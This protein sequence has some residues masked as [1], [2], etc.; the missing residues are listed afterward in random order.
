MKPTTIK[1]P[2]R[3]GAGLDYAHARMMV[4]PCGAQNLQVTSLSETKRS[5]RR[6][7]FQITS[8]SSAILR[9]ISYSEQSQVLHH[10]TLYH[11]VIRDLRWI[12]INQSKCGGDLSRKKWATLLRAGISQRLSRATPS[13]HKG[14]NDE[15]VPLRSAMTRLHIPPTSTIFLNGKLCL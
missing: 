9:S 12:H 14:V 2:K 3:E 4:T 6:V 5:L 7:G 8:N 11:T 15:I 1:E 10:C 13:S